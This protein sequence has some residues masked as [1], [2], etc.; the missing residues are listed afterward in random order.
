[1]QNESLPTKLAQ[2]SG[3][4]LRK[5]LN[6]WEDAG[7]LDGELIGAD[8]IADGYDVSMQASIE[9]VVVGGTREDRRAAFESGL[10]EIDDAIKSDRTLGGTVSRAG[11]DS[12]PD[13]TGSGRLVTDG[14]PNVLAAAIPVT[15]L[16][17]SSRTF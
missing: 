12:P 10:E 2:E 15:M 4:R 14:L 13:R 11:I 9:W 3:S 6:I 1:M 7:T 8:V 5:Y 16:F 17:T